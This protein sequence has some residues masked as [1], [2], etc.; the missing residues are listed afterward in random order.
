MITHNIKTKEGT[1]IDMIALTEIYK[2]GKK[3]R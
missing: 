3:N 1:Q 2:F